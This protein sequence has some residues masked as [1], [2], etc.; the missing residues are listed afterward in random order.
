MARLGAIKRPALLSG[1]ED[2]N[3]LLAKIA[4][5]GLARGARIGV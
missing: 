3:P 4:D 2:A 5:D 1:L